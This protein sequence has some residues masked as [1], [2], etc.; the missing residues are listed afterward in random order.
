M[1]LRPFSVVRRLALLTSVCVLALVAGAVAAPPPGP[2]SAYTWGNNW[3]GMLGYDPVAVPESSSPLVV[4]GLTGVVEVAGGGEFTLARI[5]GG[6]VRAWGA[7]D[8]GQLG[9]TPNANANPTPVSVPGIGSANPLSCNTPLAA[10][11]TAVAAGFNFGVA[12]INNGS[13]RTWG[14][15]DRGELGNGLP[16]TDSSTPVDPGLANVRAIAAGHGQ[17]YA[18]L[19]DGTIWAWGFNGSGQLGNDSTTQSPSPVQV[20]GINTAIDV[21]AGGSHGLALLSDGTVR[22]WGAGTSGQLGDAASQSRDTPVT[23]SGLS[24]VAMLAAGSS[25]SLALLSDGTLRAWGSNGDGQLGLGTVGGAPNVPVPVPG[26]DDVA[27]IGSGATTSYA[28]KE[29][30]TLWAWGHNDE[31]QL[32]VGSTTANNPTP[33][34]VTALGNGVVSVGSSPMGAFNGTFGQAVAIARPITGLNPGLVSFGEQAPG[35]A[36][37]PRPVTVTNTGASGLTIASVSIGGTDAADFAKTADACTGLTLAGGASCEVQV[38][39]AP[40]ATGARNAALEV[41]SN[42]PFS[43]QRASLSGGLAAVPPGGTDT[44]RPVIE[45]LSMTRRFA[46]NRRGRRETPV[47]AQ[48]RRARKGTTLTY[49]VSEA[50]RVVFVVQ[51]TRPGRRVGSRCRKPTRANQKRRRCKRYVLFGAFAQNAAAGRNTKRWSGRVGR[52][53]LSAG[54]YRVTLVA[55]D[56]A[57]NR[58]LPRR[59]AFRV[60]KR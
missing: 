48:R 12:L 39:F 37:A 4:P 47:P 10:C 11:A 44:T 57:G 31:G 40:A 28:L 13:I 41:A 55:I 26:L 51:R 50:A 35:T 27:A 6:R 2:G 30:G 59:R 5:S 53:S 60:V 15:D 38:T 7:N 33:T 42:A 36:S 1:A 8:D 19:A 23:V 54:P 32:G 29:D 18:Q 25:H 46:V 45:R 56:E 3:N 17:A 52:K 9:T 43:P 20:S 22:A 14:N 34:Q 58:S 16:E 24:G 49:S 21:A